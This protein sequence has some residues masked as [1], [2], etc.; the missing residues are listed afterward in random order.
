MDQSVASPGDE[1]SR[2]ADPG[3]ITH[4]IDNVSPRAL[5]YG[6]TADVYQ[7]TWRCATGDILVALKVFRFVNPGDLAVQRVSP[8]FVL[9]SQYR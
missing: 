8:A 3:N 5:R 1:R 2:G 7:G 9:Y 4:E 6:G